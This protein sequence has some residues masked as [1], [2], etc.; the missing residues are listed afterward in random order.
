MP[1]RIIRDG[2]LTSP[3]INRLSESAELFYRRLMSVV[4]DHGRYFADTML[5]MSACYPRRLNRITE[6]AIASHLAE[7]QQA[8]LL[9]VYRV[10]DQDYLQLDDFG[11]R[12]QAKSK[13]PD[14]PDSASHNGD[15]PCSTVESRLVGVVVEGVVEGGKPTVP[16]KRKGKA[17]E[18]N[19]TDWFAGV[20]DAV[21]PDDPLYGWADKAA[22]PR[23]WIA[24]AWAAFADRYTAKPDKTY[25]DWRAAFRD[26][27]KRGWLDIWRADRTGA[28]LLTTVGEQW[29]KAL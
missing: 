4:D 29:R 15:S 17:A 1:T 18:Q 2:I 3:R 25:A 19:F 20:E 21:A 26:H 9:E 11:Q 28:F 22:I 24:Y 8:G 5:L 23:E 27:V 14:K 7:C 10:E 6:E 13:F 12:V 16:V